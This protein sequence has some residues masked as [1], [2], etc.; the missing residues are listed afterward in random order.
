MQ[1]TPDVGKTTN[2][3]RL[4]E[5]GK[6]WK[7]QHGVNL[8]VI[9]D[10]GHVAKGVSYHLGKAE[11]TADAYSIQNARDKA[12]LTNAA[13]A[14]DLGKLS[15]SLA[16][17]RVF[18]AWL[19]ARCLAD[20]AVR[21]DVREII[22]SPEGKTVQRYSGVD[23]KIHTGPGNGDLTHRTHTHISFFRDSE[24]RDKVFLFQPFF[25]VGWGPDVSPAIRAVDPPALR[26]AAAIRRTGHDFGSLIDLADLKVALTR[27]G[28]Q[29]GSVVD[30]SDVQALLGPL[31]LGAP[32]SDA[33]LEH[34]VAGS[35]RH[36]TRRSRDA[37]D[38]PSGQ[39]E[40]PSPAADQEA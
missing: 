19:V 38:R 32:Q 36:G 3:P 17:L 40:E 31:A 29:F 24:K 28:H 14:I 6:F 21:H 25:Q 20:P 34:P 13:S 22:Y 7:A 35:V 15:G 26:V 8:G 1:E 2:P 18:S 12:G 4:V 27:A 5:L 37:D 16:N 11:L 30:P 10:T 39:Q 9:G 23:N 33:G